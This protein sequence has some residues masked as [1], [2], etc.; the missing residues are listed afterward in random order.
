MAP[1][2]HSSTLISV[3]VEMSMHYF[4]PSLGASSPLAQGHNCMPWRGGPNDP[5][6]GKFFYTTRGRILQTHR[7]FKPPT[8]TT[9][10]CNPHEYIWKLGAEKDEIS[11]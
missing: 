3:D 7:N 10:S 1:A 4:N 8:S 2:D 6:G 9:C 11:S 5:T